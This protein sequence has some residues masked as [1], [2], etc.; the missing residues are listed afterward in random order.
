MVDS[1]TMAGTRRLISLLDN[2]VASTYDW[3][4][5]GA[6]GLIYGRDAMLLL[7]AG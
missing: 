6:C 5:V 3:E 7:L 2:G 1:E 4:L